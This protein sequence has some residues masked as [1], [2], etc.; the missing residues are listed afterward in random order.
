[1]ALDQIAA[2]VFQHAG[3]MTCKGRPGNLVLSADTTVDEAASIGE[4]VK[5]RGLMVPSVYGGGIPV[6][7]SLEAG[8]DGMRRL[9][10]N[11]VAAGA[12]SLLMGGSGAEKCSTCTTRRLPS[13][14]L[15]G[16]E[17]TADHGQ[18]A[19]RLEL[20]GPAMPQCI[21]PVGHKN[22]SLWSIRGTSSSTRTA[23]S[24]PWT[25]PRP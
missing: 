21:E 15:R 23:N 6:A 3:L 4:E 25:T 5:R 14:R 20:E 22:F 12:E 9:I 10:D 16:R 24:T 1:M 8:I 11:C 7:K 19:W 13:V 17:G 18:A 2:A